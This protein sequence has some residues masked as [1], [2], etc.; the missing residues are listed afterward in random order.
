[1]SKEPAHGFKSDVCLSHLEIEEGFNPRMRANAIPTEE[2]VDSIRVRGVDEP[3]HVR[4]KEGHDKLLVVD[5]H[6][7]LMAASL[8][9]TVKTV[10]VIDHGFMSDKEALFLALTLNLNDNQK[11]FT[12]KEI[13]GAVERLKDMGMTVEE[14]SNSLG[15]KKSTVYNYLAV[16]RVTPKLRELAEADPKDGGIPAVVVSRAALLSKEAQNALADK[17][18]GKNRERALQEIKEEKRSTGK[19]PSVK[20]SKEEAGGTKQDIRVLTYGETREVK[21]KVA[22]DY[23]ERCKALDEEVTRRM[24]RAPSDKEYLGM[25]KV[26]ACIKGRLTVEDVFRWDKV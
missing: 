23:R 18:K 24:R 13:I 10:K 4:R 20:L 6:R 11:A 26:L 8:A 15:R 21:Y 22:S 17:L 3:I 14:I 16:T 7:R 12:K 25:S 2:L 19:A 1:M 5:G 9:L